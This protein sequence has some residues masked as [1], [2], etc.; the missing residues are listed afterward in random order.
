MFSVHRLAAKPY[1]VL[2]ASATDS[3]GVRNV[4]D[5]RTGPNISTWAIVDDGAT[6]VKSV[7]G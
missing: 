7:G 1:G 4:I 2:L 3:S 6:S 5:T